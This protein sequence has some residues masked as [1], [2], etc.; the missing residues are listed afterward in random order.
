LWTVVGVQI[1][2]DLPTQ[3]GWIVQNAETFY[4]ICRA[5]LYNEPVLKKQ[6]VIYGP[7]IKHVY[8]EVPVGTRVVDLFSKMGIEYPPQ[9]DQPVLLD[10][11]PGWC[12]EIDSGP[13]E[14]TISKRTNGVMLADREFVEKYSACDPPERIN[15]LKDKNWTSEQHQTTPRQYSPEL[16]AIPLISNPYLPDIVKKSKPAVE[17]GDSVDAGD[18]VAE[19]DSKGISNYQ[20]ASIDGVVVK[21]TGD[22]IFIEK[23]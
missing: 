15:A 11:G 12:S 14:A 1:G 16:V 21:I 8:F 19:P 2:R 23:N 5:I 10:G 20:H 4:N 17:E 9:E 3:H 7:E 6:V 18:I 22:K 13:E